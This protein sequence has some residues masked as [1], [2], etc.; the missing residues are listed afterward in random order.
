MRV[1]TIDADTGKRVF[2]RKEV[3]ILIGVSPQTI[4]LWEK[5]GLI[6]ET[7]R[8]E[9]GYRYWTEEEIETLRECVGKFPR[10]RHKK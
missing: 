5:K 9:N 7:S 10:G 4:N 3:S 1:I 2:S 6:P 8:D